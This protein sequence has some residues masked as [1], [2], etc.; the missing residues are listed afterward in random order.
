MEEPPL[1]AIVSGSWLLVDS[2]TGRGQSQIPYWQ[3][4]AAGRAPHKPRKKTYNLQEAVGEKT[5]FWNDKLLCLIKQHFATTVFYRK[6][7][8]SKT[9]GAYPRSSAPIQVLWIWPF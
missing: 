4:P 7:V 3:P 2:G 6:I 9:V 8:V 5:I 1:E